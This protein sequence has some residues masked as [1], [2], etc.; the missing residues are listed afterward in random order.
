[1]GSVM[2][3][4]ERPWRKIRKT[5]GTVLSSSFDEGE[6][7]GAGADGYERLCFIDAPS[8]RAGDTRAM[9]TTTSA[10]R[11]ARTT[12]DDDPEVKFLPDEEPEG[13]ALP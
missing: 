11:K 5:P 10:R 9:A 4:R 1:M 6:S 12:R 7:D 13:W 8:G 3:T 2:P